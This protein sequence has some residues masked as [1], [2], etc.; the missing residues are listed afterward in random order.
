MR[1]N[2]AD[3]REF[4]G[5]LEACMQLKAERDAWRKRAEVLEDALSDE[6]AAGILRAAD[7]AALERA[8]AERDEAQAALAK[9]VLLV[10]QASEALQKA[11]IERDRLRL[12]VANL[13][14]AY[15]GRTYK[16]TP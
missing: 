8:E 1:G 15:S 12:Q 6:F 3:D 2:E 9:G 7:A 5:L 16:V 10:A 4:D 14:R 11:M 13:H